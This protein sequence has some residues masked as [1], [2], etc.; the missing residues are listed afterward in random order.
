MKKF[1]KIL[2]V[3]IV[4]A[5][6]L[7]GV[8]ALALKLMFPLA[9]LKVMAQE[10]VAQNY[11][12]DID[13]SDVSLNL[14]GVKIKSF[15]LSDEGGFEAGNFISADSA[16]V[17]VELMPLFKKQIKISTIGFDGVE[18]NV[19][20]NA[21]GKFNFDNLIPASADE[22]SPQPEQDQ[23]SSAPLAMDL[24]AKDIYIKN[25]DVTY[26]DLQNGM[27][28]SVEDVNFTVDD[29]DYNNPF[30]FELSFNTS[31]NTGNIKITPVKILAKGIVNIA[32]MELEKASAEITDFAV[33]YKGFRINMT[34]GISNLQ[35]PDLSLKGEIS[36]IDSELA[37][38]FVSGDI[39]SFAL[40]VINLEAKAS[41]DLENSKA[42][43]S[44]FDISLGKSY[45]K[46]TA[47]VDFSK[48]EISYAE[49]T[50]L[51]VNL[52]EVSD[53][54]KEL[55][56]AFKLK[57]S[58]TGDIKAVSAGSD[59]PL[60]TGSVVLKDIGAAAMGKILSSLNGEIK[61]NSLDDIKTNTIKGVFD[62]SDFKTSLAYKNNKKM[63]VDFMFN[64]DKFTLEDID[65]DE[66]LASAEGGEK[67]ETV[68]S[69]KAATS[70]GASDLQMAPMDVK[71][72]IIIKRVENNVFSTDN[73]TFKADVKDLDLTMI[74]ASG[75]VYFA[76][77][78]GEIRDLDKLI[79]SSVFLKVA[80]TTVKIAQKALKATQIISGADINT[81]SVSYKSIV[82]DYR[83]G[84]GKATINKSDLNS[85]LATIN[86][87][88]SINFVTQQL[89]M[90]VKVGLGKNASGSADIKVGGSIEDP[91][92]KLDV[93]STVS[94][95][96]GSDRKETAKQAVDNVKNTVKDV[97]SGIK[98]LFKKK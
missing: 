44:K 51:N 31:V 69:D 53:I 15:K 18:I 59:K 43:V 22:V 30:S 92:F 52:S 5:V 72:D 70:S 3:L 68:S 94:S 25:S 10:Y 93:V 8:A 14:I 48:P 45:I 79:N 2:A 61:I 95:L 57:G 66:L 17:K 97:T 40:P 83:L 91:S 11:N 24:T 16:V 96:L 88:G 76:S 36:G 47:A 20:K 29:F 64:M 98:N 54:S 1:I 71:A 63:A 74:K 49:S 65:F 35:M 75:T 84:G 56:A 26:K 41:A 58:V 62:G 73:L 42:E 19:I 6:V 9:K 60:V 67:G 21:D 38:E 55:L 12:R 50:S 78:D 4:I 80:L 39:P 32:G 89:D 13:F 82:G 86:T 81:D 77:S 27:E 28:F 23:L 33:E 34:G 87:S 37:A 7:L 46:N 85:D 90:T